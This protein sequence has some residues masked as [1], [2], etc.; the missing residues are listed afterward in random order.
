ME[1]LKSYERYSGQAINLSKLA[2]FFSK[3]TLHR[4]W[5]QLAQRMNISYVGARDKYLGLPSII[6]KSNT[7]TFAAIKEKVGK[8]IQSWQRSLLLATGRVTLLKE[9]GEAIPIYSMACFKLPETLPMDLHR[10]MQIFGGGK[11]AWKEK[12][13]G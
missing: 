13:L 6:H 3:N 12:W 4:L 1:V 9:V 7:T 5:T 8:K 2:M 10:M 11:K